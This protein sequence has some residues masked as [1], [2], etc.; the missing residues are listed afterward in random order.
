MRGVGANAQVVGAVAVHPSG[1]GVAE[2]E[3][4]SQAPGAVTVKLEGRLEVG[5]LEHREHAAGVGHLELAVQVDL[6][7]DGVD[8]AV[9][10]LAGVRVGGVGDDGELVLGCEAVELDADAV[11]D[12][13]R[14]ELDAVE[15]DRVHGRA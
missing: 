14:V 8:E 9:Q 3:T 10:A 11:A 5:L 13:G 6:V 12:D 2:L 15:G 1:S 4:T 7:V